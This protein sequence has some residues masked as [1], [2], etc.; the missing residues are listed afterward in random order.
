METL[1]LHM[2][3]KIQIKQNLL[4]NKLA[5]SYTEGPDIKSRCRNLLS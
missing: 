1:A 5:V 4:P 2:N 3:L